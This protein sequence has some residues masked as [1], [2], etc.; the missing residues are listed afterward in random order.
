MNTGVGGFGATTSTGDGCAEDCARAGDPRQGQK[1]TKSRNTGRKSPEQN[2]VAMS[3]S[4]MLVVVTYTSMT[5]I[6]EIGHQC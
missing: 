6:L 2:F 3:L 1:M 4:Y 5:K